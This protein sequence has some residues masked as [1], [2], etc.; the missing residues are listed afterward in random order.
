MAGEFGA[1]CGMSDSSLEPRELHFLVAALKD[2]GLVAG[3]LQHGHDGLPN[4]A[5][6]EPEQVGGGGLG[7][8]AGQGNS[9]KG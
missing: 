8:G 1:R 2:A 9:G 3:W 7:L 5:G 6:F 4:R